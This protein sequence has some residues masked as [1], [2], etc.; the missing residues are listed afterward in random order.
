MCREKAGDD[1]VVFKEFA[2]VVSIDANAESAAFIFVLCP[3]LKDS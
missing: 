2:R 3:F 1:L